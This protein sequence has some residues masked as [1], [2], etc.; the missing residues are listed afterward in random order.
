MSGPRPVLKGVR[1]RLLALCVVG[2]SGA[3]ACS[4]GAAATG[5]PSIVIEV[6]SSSV[7]VEN[8]TGTSL[9]KGQVSLIPQ[10]IPRPYV[11]LLPYMSSGEKRTF[12]FSAFRA[13]DGTPFR[14]DVAQGRSVKV[15]A[16]D[17]SGKA[18][19]REVPFK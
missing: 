14:Q 10:G 6:A 12:P 18:H 1:A 7:T 16:T 9:S 4:G 19:E 8:Q 5:D 11:A 3:A 15:T 13:Q 17:A 2:F